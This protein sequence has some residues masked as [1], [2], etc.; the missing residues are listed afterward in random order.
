LAKRRDPTRHHLHDPHVGWLVVEDQQLARSD[1]IRGP[2][3]PGSRM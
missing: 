3:Y 2:C 1:A